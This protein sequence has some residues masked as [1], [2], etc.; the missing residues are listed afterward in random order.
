MA[1]WYL[2]GYFLQLLVAATLYLLSNLSRVLLCGGMVRL[3]WRALTPPV[4]EVRSTLHWASSSAHESMEG[5]TGEEGDEGGEGDEGKIEKGL[6]CTPENKQPTAPVL[7]PFLVLQQ[8]REMSYNTSQPQPPLSLDW[9]MPTLRRKLLWYHSQGYVML[10]A[11]L[12]VNVPSMLL[13]RFA[14][15]DLRSI[16]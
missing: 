11:G 14:R 3:L 10:A 6:A 9:V 1:E 5:R 13:L 15:Q 7:A 4:F 2:N 8:D 16:Y 12:L